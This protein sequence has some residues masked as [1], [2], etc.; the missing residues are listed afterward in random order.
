[1]GM[2]GNTGTALVT[3]IYASVPTFFGSR[4]A[5]RKGRPTHTGIRAANSRHSDRREIAVAIVT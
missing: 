5:V 2:R 4:R 1:M 3:S